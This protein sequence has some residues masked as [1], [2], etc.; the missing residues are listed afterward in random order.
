VSVLVEIH[1]LEVV[2]RHGVDEKERRDGQTFL[3]DVALEVTEPTQDS[4]DATVDYRVV[5]DLIRRLSDERSYLLIESLASAV[6]DALL[7]ELPL[8]T[9][10]VSVRK[11]AIDWAEWTSATVERP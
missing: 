5:R 11:P 2:G 10:R 6:A 1:G 9:V 4:I 7:A 3:F 8:Q